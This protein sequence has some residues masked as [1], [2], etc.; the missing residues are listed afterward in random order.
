MR[1][2]LNLLTLGVSDLRKSIAFYQKGLGWQTRG[3]VGE[4][5][6]NGAVV[7]FELDNGMMLCLYERKNLAWDSNLKLEPESATEFSIGYFVNSN[8]EVDAIMKQAAKAGAKITKSA[9]KAFW[10][11]YHGYFQDIDGHLWEIGHNPSWKVKE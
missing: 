7:L 4:E 1:Q 10:G 8:N 9:Q 5:Y 6:E 11:G 2:R 3:I